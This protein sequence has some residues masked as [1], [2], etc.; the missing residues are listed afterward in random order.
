[1]NCTEDVGI[2]LHVPQDKLIKIK[3]CFSC[4]GDFVPERTLGN[5][6]DIFD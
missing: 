5:V 6:W 4:R 2:L 1:M 3:Q